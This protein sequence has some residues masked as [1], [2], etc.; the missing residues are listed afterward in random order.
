MPGARPSLMS[1]TSPGRPSCPALAE[2]ARDL[3]FLHTREARVLRS[4]DFAGI[5]R[6][7]GLAAVRALRRAAAAYG[8]LAAK[9]DN[10]DRRGYAAA[11]RSALAAD[12]AIRRALQM[13]RLVGYGT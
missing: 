5:A 2:A 6:P 8:S 4:L 12:A 11:R 1:S 13:L 7:G 10:G 9:A 3:A